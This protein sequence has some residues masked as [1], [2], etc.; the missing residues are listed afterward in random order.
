M[1]ADALDVPLLRC[2][3]HIGTNEGGRGEG[4][5]EGRRMNVGGRRE[6]GS[7]GEGGEGR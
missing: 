3:R 2:D 5:G 7:R 6:G 4:G 1:G